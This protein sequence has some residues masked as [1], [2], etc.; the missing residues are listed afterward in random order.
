MF[1]TGW[2]ERLLDI[3]QSPAI[4]LYDAKRNGG[5]WVGK[6]YG[7]ENAYQPDPLHRSPRRDGLPGRALL[8]AA[9]QRPPR[10][11]GAQRADEADAVAAGIRHKFVKGL[12]GRPGVEMYRKSGTWQDFT[13]TARS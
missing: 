10:Q 6:S 13:P 8:L 9:R 12:E 5:L 11:P 1:S 3:L 2:Q 7:R 4:A